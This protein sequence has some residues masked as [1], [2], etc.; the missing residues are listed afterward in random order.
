MHLIVYTHFNRTVYGCRLND[1][2]PSV[3]VAASAKHILN[4]LLIIIL[5]GWNIYE[6]LCGRHF[7]KYFP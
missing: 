5:E 7:V 2:Y 1:S 3:R 4:C 6:R